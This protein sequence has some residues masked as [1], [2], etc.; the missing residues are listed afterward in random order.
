MVRT[1]KY[2]VS[3]ATVQTVTQKTEN[4]SVPLDGRALSAMKVG[5]RCL[6]LGHFEE[7][8]VNAVLY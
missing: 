5:H 7:L 2:V 4:A 1:A 3:A 8:F 6:K